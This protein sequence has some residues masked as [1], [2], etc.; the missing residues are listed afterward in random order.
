MPKTIDRLG[1]AFFTSGALN[2]A[3]AALFLDLIEDEPPAL[4]DLAH[5]GENRPREAARLLE[6]IMDACT[7]KP[8]GLYR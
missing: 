7:G 2:G 4:R 1:K 8:Q 3:A 5:V 6:T